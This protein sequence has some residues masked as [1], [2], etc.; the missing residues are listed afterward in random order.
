MERI[1]HA[2]EWK[3]LARSRTL[4]LQRA[5]FSSIQSHWGYIGECGSAAYDWLCLCNGIVPL[6]C[7]AIYSYHVGKTARP[8]TL[9]EVLTW[10]SHWCV[11]NIFL[12]NGD[13]CESWLDNAGSK[14]QV[15]LLILKFCWPQVKVPGSIPGGHSQ[16]FLR[17]L[18]FS[19]PSADDPKIPK[20]SFCHAHNYKSFI[21]FWSLNFLYLAF[22]W[23]I[24]LLIVLKRTVGR[25]HGV[26]LKTLKI[27]TNTAV[28][29]RRF[30][31]GFRQ[32][33]TIVLS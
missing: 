19:I 6:N 24:C 20:N 13:T 28:R 18:P 21:A 14:F 5:I 26:V 25:F 23:R 1:L 15:N 27:S 7:D 4:G 31:T 9:L 16:I 2:K 8:R 10:Q 3:W 12:R 17:T 22:S 30:C 32:Y 29:K 33:Q 11:F